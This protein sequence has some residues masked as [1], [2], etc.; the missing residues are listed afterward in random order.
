[1]KKDIQASE[2]DDILLL[3]DYHQSLDDFP[4]VLDDFP[5]LQRRHT[6]VELGVGERN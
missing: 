2:L 6:S 3:G 1:M 5:D 4:A